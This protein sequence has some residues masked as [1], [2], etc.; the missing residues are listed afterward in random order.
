MGVG[1]F[2]W[3][4]VLSCVVVHS[5]E[6]PEI[7]REPENDGMLLCMACERAAER[8]MTAAA[9][10]TKRISKSNAAMLV[11]AM[12]EDE[13]EGHG[14]F[15]TLCQRTVTKSLTKELSAMLVTRGESVKE[16]WPSL[17]GSASADGDATDP[18][19]YK[20]V[21]LPMCTFKKALR[22]KMGEFAESVGGPLPALPF[23]QLS[24]IDAIIE[25]LRLNLVITT[26]SIVCIISGAV[27]LQYR[28][29]CRY[30]KHLAMEQ[31]RLKVQRQRRKDLLV[32]ADRTS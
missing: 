19:V 10:S 31:A 11:G 13:S 20:D 5:L 14:R 2:C 32:A 15:K 21:C 3:L 24:L 8:L 16:M 30:H 17:A 9:S 12:C 26:V 1:S 18:L 27:F 29:I 28:I 23:P 22:D 4:I 7:H 6:K 25:F